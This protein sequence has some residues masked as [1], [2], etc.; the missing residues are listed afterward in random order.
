MI[1]FS[2]RILITHFV[3]AGPDKGVALCVIRIDSWLESQ[4]RALQLHLLPHLL[5]CLSPDLVLTALLQDAL[6]AV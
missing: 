3:Q 5:R 1:N 4:V 2:F 6:H